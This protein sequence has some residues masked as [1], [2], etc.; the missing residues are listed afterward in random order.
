VGTRSRRTS[1]SWRLTAD[2]TFRSPN[3]IPIPLLRSIRLES[4]MSLSL[5]FSGRTSDSETATGDAGYQHQSSSSE[6][7][8]APRANY[9]F[10]SRVTGGLTAEWRDSQDDS[11]GAPRKSHVRELGIWV[12]FSF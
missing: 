2:Y 9:S 1:S 3:G 12:E 6:F 7:S 4:Q 10:S 5:T 11:G 8:V